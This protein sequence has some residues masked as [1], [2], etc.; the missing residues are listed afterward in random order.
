MARK[1]KKKI[2]PRKRQ[3]SVSSLEKRI[4]DL[5]RREAI[6]RKELRKAKKREAATRKKK[7]KL[8]AVKKKVRILKELK[9]R[10]RGN[11]QRPRLGLSR[12]YRSGFK[13]FL[14]RVDKR[15]GRFR[16]YAIVRVVLLDYPDSPTRDLSVFLGSRTSTEA[17]AFSNREILNRAPQRWGALGDD[18]KVLFIARLK[19][20]KF[21][22]PRGKPDK[23]RSRIAKR[24]PRARKSIAAAN[25]KRRQSGLPFHP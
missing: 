8:A 19:G 16:T 21:G 15:K 6:L 18:S 4:A 3:F 13:P 7:K 5:D 14:E 24:N 1:R 22:G 23:V 2:R 10:G 25:I 9:S 11:R 12:D 20:G 17:K